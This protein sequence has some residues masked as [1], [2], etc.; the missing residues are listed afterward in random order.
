M[1]FSNIFPFSE[2]ILKLPH[3]IYS[4]MTIYIYIYD[5]Y[6]NTHLPWQIH[7]YNLQFQWQSLGFLLFASLSFRQHSLDAPLRARRQELEAAAAPEVV[8]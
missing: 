2:D 3:S 8:T 1:E 5:M 7:R 4:G 6:Y